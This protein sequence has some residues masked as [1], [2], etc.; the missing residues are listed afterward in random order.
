MS[1]LKN[2][3]NLSDLEFYRCA[4]KLQ[5]DITDFALRDFGLKKSPRSVRQVIKDID[6]ADQETVDGIFAKYGKRPN[7]EF[8]SEYPAWF[9][10]DRKRRLIGYTDAL[11][12]NI[13]GAN[14]IYAVSI[15][16]CDLRREKQDEAIGICGKLYREFQYIRRH[17]PVNLNWIAGT[18]ALIKREEQLLKG[19]RQSDNRTRNAVFERTV[20]DVNGIV[21]PADGYVSDNVKALSEI[22]SLIRS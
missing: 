1:V 5:D 7:Q 11:M 3:R 4:E 12:D 6:E 10:Y 20:R 19:W 15:R 14:L 16:E 9:V 22:I 13:V 8:Q 21:S 17:L 18:L 2:L